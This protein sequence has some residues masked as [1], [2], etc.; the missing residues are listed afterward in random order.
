MFNLRKSW[1]SYHPSQEWPSLAT[2]LALWHLYA[3]TKLFLYNGYAHMASYL[4][5]AASI[6]CVT[7]ICLHQVICPCG[8]LSSTTMHP[9]SWPIDIS[10]LSS[11][12]PCGSSLME[13]HVAIHLFQYLFSL[14]P[15]FCLLFSVSCGKDPPLL[16]RLTHL[17]FGI[18]RVCP[19]A[20]S[21]ARSQPND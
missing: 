3:T 5:V 1:P 12:V 10:A 16:W 6:P 15:S 20:C 2:L 14:M 7:S 13:Y 9:A 11:W 17:F 8:C 21:Y 19:M 18:T 4:A